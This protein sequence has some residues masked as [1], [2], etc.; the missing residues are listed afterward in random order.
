MSAAEQ[1]ARLRFVVASER[2]EIAE[3]LGQS[4]RTDVREVVHEIERLSAAVQRVRPD[5]LLVDLGSSPQEVLSHLEGLP[6]PRPLLIV[7][8]PDDSGLLRRA[9]QLGAREYLT[10]SADA[11]DE[12]LAALERL[13]RERRHGEA[14]ASAPMVTVMGA[15]GGVGATF[16]ACQLAAGLAHRGGRVAVV[17]MNLRLG[18]V[19][20]YFDLRPQ[21]TMANLVGAGGRIDSA[22][23]DTVLAT[24]P[25]SGVQVLAAPERPEE[26]DAIPFEQT[27]AALDLLREQH[28]WV[29]V[30]ISPNFDD[31][32]VH[33]LDRASHML[34]VTTSDVPA[35]NHARLQLGLLK[36]LG[37]A[38]HKIRVVVN[39]M[40]GRA[41]VQSRQIDDF[42]HRKCDLVVPNDYRTASICVNEGRPLW[43]V[44]PQS[45]LRAAFEGL[46][47]ATHEWCGVPLPDGARKKEGGLRGLLWR[48]HHGAA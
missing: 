40:D 42:L 11:K 44:A 25:T 32:S 15:K 26:A 17:D 33:V 21:Y 2:A 27:D 3:A 1:H 48:R 41:A 36:R 23:L 12:L 10:P 6:T 16:V 39:R 13:V 30:D 18:D 31:R 43:E 14:R 35:L 7:W 24:H 4:G 46:V 19:A 45:A 28:D 8:G 34:I 5:A 22:F 29:V 9:M 47:E 37:H 20:L 38:A